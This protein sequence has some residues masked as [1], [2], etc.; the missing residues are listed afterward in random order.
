MQRQS[1][2][3]HLSA[4]QFRHTIK[5]RFTERI[6]P[7]ST[8]ELRKDQQKIFGLDV[9]GRCQKIY[10]ELH[11]MYTGNMTKIAA[12]MPKV[13]EATLFVTVTQVIAVS[14]DA[15]PLCVGAV[16]RR[17]GGQSLCTSAQTI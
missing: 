7:G 6:F 4:G 13:I 17:V 1:D 12:R 14:A 10:T 16:G 3:T 11:A 15:M 9:K 8:A 2:T 5:T